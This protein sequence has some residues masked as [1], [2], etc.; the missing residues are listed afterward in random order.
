[1]SIYEE[2]EIEDMVF[3][4]G[5]EI[6]YYPC[7]CGDQFNISLEELYDGEDIA[8][9]PSCT[10]RIRVIFDEESLPPLKEDLPDHVVSTESTSNNE[11]TQ[12]TQTSSSSSS[13]PSS[14]SV[15]DND[16]LK[17]KQQNDNKD[18]N[19]GEKSIAEKIDL[20]KQ[21]RIIFTNMNDNEIIT[22]EEIT[23]S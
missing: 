10:L 14:S 5:T 13:S 16:I 2:I 17:D 21:E 23:P 8:T 6:Y 19:I 22:T 3:D 18:K 20:N 9:C 11:H 12:T 15:N 4:E 1:M 7:P